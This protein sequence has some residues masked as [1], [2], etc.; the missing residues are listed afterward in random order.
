MNVEPSVRDIPAVDPQKTRLVREFPH[1][2]AAAC[3]RFDSGGERLFVGSEDNAIQVWNLASGEKTTLIGHDSW[4]RGFVWLKSHSTLASSG[5][6]G[7]VIW[8]SLPG[9]PPG[10]VRRIQAQRG[11]IRALTVSPDE[12]WLATGGN[13]RVVRIWSSR[14]GSLVAELPAHHHD[15]YSLAFHPR[16]EFLVSGDYFGVLKVWETS[17]WKAVREFDA[18]VMFASNKSN[19]GT[20]G[21]LRSLAFSADGRTLVGSGVVGG[22]DPLGQAVKPGAITFDWQSGERIA[23]LRSRGGELGVGWGVQCHPT[24]GFVTA[25]SGGMSAK[26]L[27]FWNP[28]DEQP[29]HVVDLPSAARDAA[30]HPDG[31]HLAI[32]L[33]DGR[34]QLYALG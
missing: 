17:S 24:A 27:Y 9:S 15:V 14:E 2:R 10:E 1:G 34:I 19:R 32:A 16:G 23:V 33:Y 13:D 22:E 5:Y 7:R 6:D 31:R 30:L 4:V 11:W 12:R 18:H 20:C 29:F 25:V 3:C 21:G 28:G 8:W 26:Q